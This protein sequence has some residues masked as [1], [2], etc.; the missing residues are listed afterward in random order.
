MLILWSLPSVRSFHHFFYSFFTFL[1]LFLWRR[2]KEHILSFPSLHVSIHMFFVLYHFL[3]F[4][5]Y[6]PGQRN[7]YSLYF[8]RHRYTYVLRSILLS[9][10]SLSCLICTIFV[11]MI[12]LLSLTFS[13]VCD[14]SRCSYYLRVHDL[15]LDI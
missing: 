10:F 7:I 9:L 1:F 14:P 11:F 6:D 12:Y 13:P 8:V 3:S 5:S 15:S 4:C 2:S